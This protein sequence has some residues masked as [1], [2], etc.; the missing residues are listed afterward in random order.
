VI[1]SQGSHDWGG[2]PSSPC[3]DYCQDRMRPFSH[4]QHFGNVFSLFVRFSFVFLC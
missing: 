2:W 3:F 1:L 4:A